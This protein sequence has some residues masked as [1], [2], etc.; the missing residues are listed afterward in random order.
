MV[1]PLLARSVHRLWRGEL[2][3]A[4]NDLTWILERSKLSLDAQDNADARARLVTVATWQ[5]RLDDTRALVADGLVLLAET[6]E[7]YPIAELCLA[8]MAAE[9]AIAE[10]AAARRDE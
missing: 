6:D 5:G 8:G 3:L 9:A 10:R 4:R 7:I 1:Y 2:D